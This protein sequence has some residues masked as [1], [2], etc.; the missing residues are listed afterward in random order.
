MCTLPLL[1]GENIS[2][3]LSC[4][5]SPRPWTSSSTWASTSTAYRRVNEIV[6]VPGRVEND[7]IEVEPIFERR[8]G[9]LRRTRGMPPRVELYERAGID[10]HALLSE[11]TGSPEQQGREVS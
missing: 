7:V 10:V 1:A 2:A 9:D 8:G 3:R 5:R 4:R 11:P 6:A